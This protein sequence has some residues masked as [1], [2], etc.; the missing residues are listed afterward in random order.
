LGLPPFLYRPAG[1]DL[2]EVPAFPDEWLFRTDPGDRGQPEGWQRPD[3]N[4]AEWRTLPVPAE[5]GTTPV[6][7]YEGAAWYRVR[8]TPPADLAGR[9]L[10]LR[11]GA[12]DEEAWV[13]LNGELVGEHSAASTGQT[14]HQIWDKP[15]DLPLPKVR[16][17]AENVLAVRVQNSMLAGGIFKPVK[18]YVATSAQ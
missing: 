10:I 1:A 15:F 6:G 17:G 4:E 14:V 18:L 11:F 9:K 13:Y 7:R 3:L 16:V 2:A 12:V 8:F 5:W